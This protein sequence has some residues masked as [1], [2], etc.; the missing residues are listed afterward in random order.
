M[1]VSMTPRTLSRTVSSIGSHQSSKSMVPA[2]IA[3][4]FVVF[5][6]MAWSPFRR[7][8][9]GISWGEHPGDYANRISTTSAT[10]PATPSSTSFVG[11]S[12]AQIHQAKCSQSPQACYQ[13]ATKIC[14]GSYQVL[15]SESHAGGLAADV[16]PGPVT[17]YG[18]TFSCGASDGRLPSFV[19]R[20]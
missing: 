4:V 18:M 15:D 1:I 5:F 17:W 10:G 20:G 14:N 16:L 7:S 3:A 19:F 9:A 13:E 2:A 12:G 11:P 6:V 8:N